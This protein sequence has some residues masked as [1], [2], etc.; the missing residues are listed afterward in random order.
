MLC[1]GRTFA[2]EDELTHLINFKSSPTTVRPRTG[3]RHLIQ[4]LKS[5]IENQEV[6]KEFMVRCISFLRSLTEL[7]K[8]LLEA[9]NILY[10]RSSCIF[11]DSTFSEYSSSWDRASALLF[12][13]CC[14]ISL[15]P[16]RPGLL[17]LF[18]VQRSHPCG[19]KNKYYTEVQY[20]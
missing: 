3:I 7:R 16:H 15:F 18:P 8:C 14:N 4:G 6:L 20:K 2:S 1:V 5:R 11:T 10:G 13:S 19:I 9:F 12:E 17:T